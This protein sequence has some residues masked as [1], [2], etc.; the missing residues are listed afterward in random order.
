MVAARDDTG[1]IERRPHGT[2]RRRV[3]RRTP[4]AGWPPARIDDLDRL[5]DAVGGERRAIGE[6]DITAQRQA[7]SAS[8]IHQVPL[9]AEPR[10]QVPVDV[11]REQGFV[12]RAADFRFFDDFRGDRIDGVDRV[13]LCH[14]EAATGRNHGPRLA[15]RRASAPSVR[16]FLEVRVRALVVAH[17]VRSRRGER[18][19]LAQAARC[20]RSRGRA[21]GP[22]RATAP[23]PRAAAPA[24]RFRPR[25]SERPGQPRRVAFPAR[26]SGS[27]PPP[28]AARLEIA[29]HAMG[30]RQQQ[31]RVAF[32]HARA[33]PS[34]RRER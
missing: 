2:R 27:P 7:H 26:R 28:R 1:H 20:R 29:G 14:H 16:H 3:S 22:S 5:L 10:Q 17:Q 30:P 31:P 19:Q 6:V 12:D 15:P 21:A 33:L 4:R 32:E 18:Q 24:R 13:R 9:L 25:A 34:P 8:A 11:G 23:S